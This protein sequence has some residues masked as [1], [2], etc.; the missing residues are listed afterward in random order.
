MADEICRFFELIDNCTR[1]YAKVEVL[2]D[3]LSRPSTKSETECPI[4]NERSQRGG[5][6]MKIIRRD[7]ESRL[8]MRHQFRN[9]PDVG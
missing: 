8:A 4:V 3:C 7:N 5:E 2:L 6:T 9:P 1:T